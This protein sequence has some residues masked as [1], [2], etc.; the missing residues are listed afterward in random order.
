MHS[1]KAKNGPKLM[2]IYFPDFSDNSREKQNF[3]NFWSFLAI[4]RCITF[5]VDSNLETSGSKPVWAYPY[6]WFWRLPRV[7]APFFSFKS[8]QMIF[9]L[10]WSLMLVVFE[11]LIFI[12]IRPHLLLNPYH[13]EDEWGSKMLQK[14]KN[15]LILHQISSL[16]HFFLSHF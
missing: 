4:L 13:F 12:L 14:R 6:R 8:F 15:E 2:K 1:R 3:M 16:R 9:S 11:K 7:I 10:G 5:M